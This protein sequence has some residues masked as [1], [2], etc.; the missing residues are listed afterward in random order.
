L[1]SPA[2][3]AYDSEFLLKKVHGGYQWLDYTGRSVMEVADTLRA[4]TEW[5]NILILRHEKPDGAKKRYIFDSRTGNFIK[6]YSDDKFIDIKYSPSDSFAVVRTGTGGHL[7][8]IDPNGRQT[9]DYAAGEILE[10]RV[11]ALTRSVVVLAKKPEQYK[12]TFMI[13]DGNG[14]LLFEV[15][16]VESKD[17]ITESK[18]GANLTL[19]G[20]NIWNKVFSLRLKSEVGM[21]FFTKLSDDEKYLASLVW[22]AD[23]LYR[24]EEYARLLGIHDDKITE[25]KLSD[26]GLEGMF[27]QLYF[28]E[29]YSMETG[30]MVGRIKLDGNYLKTGNTGNP[31]LQ[32]VRFSQDDTVVDLRADYQ[33]SVE[34]QTFTLARAKIFMEMI[35]KWVALHPKEPKDNIAAMK[36]NAKKIASSIQ[37]S[38]SY[39][40]QTD[41]IKKDKKQVKRLAKQI[42][43]ADEK[44]IALLIGEL[45]DISRR[46]IYLNR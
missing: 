19:S 25:A 15:Y 34:K 44:K 9:G 20:F 24:S 11:D 21:G 27:V 28:L 33:G 3:F 26:D 14:N 38:M 2:A 43:H 5:G 12:N 40:V 35:D 4:V 6:M 36:A 41:D 8:F 29:I 45:K 17:T 16:N 10:N 31:A 39:L 46:Y 32:D 30:T 1:F 23:E 7:Y 42:K 37:S 13:F 18:S 22:G